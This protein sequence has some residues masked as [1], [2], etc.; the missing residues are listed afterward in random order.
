MGVRQKL[1]SLVNFKLRS[2]HDRKPFS[3]PSSPI[4]N[5]AAF[6]QHPNGPI[7]PEPI[8]PVHS[9]VCR[10]TIDIQ[11]PLQFTYK[12]YTTASGVVIPPDFS[13]DHPKKAHQVSRSLP[14]FEWG[15]SVG[16]IGDEDTDVGRDLNSQ[17]GE[18]NSQVGEMNSELH[19]ELDSEAF[20]GDDEASVVKDDDITTGS[21]YSSNTLGRMTEIALAAHHTSDDNL[22]LRMDAPRSLPSIPETIENGICPKRRR[23]LD[24]SGRAKRK[25]RGLRNNSGG[26]KPSRMV[27]IIS[28]GEASSGDEGP[29]PARP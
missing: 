13:Y 25:V 26:N 28:G 10:R 18:M 21:D 2:H 12:S 19:D 4:R 20:D 1:K 3:P 7:N 17:V 22:H 14:N 16:S 29:R 6:Y 15:A 9:H 23:F 5:A 24:L 11:E 27:R 8:R